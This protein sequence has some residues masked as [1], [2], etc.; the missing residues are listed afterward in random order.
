MSE[1]LDFR[2][3]SRAVARIEAGMEKQN[4]RLDDIEDTLSSVRG[5]ATLGRFIL[6]F[7]GLGGLATFVV[8]L[9]GRGGT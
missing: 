4:K 1:E 7:L 9:A 6:S 3:L 8:L 5:M 2:D